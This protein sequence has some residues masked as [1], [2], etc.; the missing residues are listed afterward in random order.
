M[1]TNDLTFIIDLIWNALVVSFEWLSSLL[2]SFGID[3]VVFIVGM[4]SVMAVMKFVISPYLTG[5]SD[6]AKKTN[7]KEKL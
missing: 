1:F 3:V 2:S 6:S 4:L 7:K 5:S